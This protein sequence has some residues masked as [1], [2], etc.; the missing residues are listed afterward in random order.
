VSK[1]ETVDDIYKEIGDELRSQYRLG[2]TPADEAAKE[3]YHQISLTLNGEAGKSR[4]QITTRD[5]YYTGS[6]R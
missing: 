1:K 6:E 2:F 4:P 3:G 5:G